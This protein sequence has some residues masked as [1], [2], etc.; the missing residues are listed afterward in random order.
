MLKKFLI[1]IIFS[2][3]IFCEEKF[4]FVQKIEGV[5][6][7]WTLKHNEI[8][9]V[10]E[11]IVTIDKTERNYEKK[12]LEIAKSQILDKKNNF[13]SSKNGNLLK[14][15]DVTFYEVDSYEDSKKFYLWIVSFDNKE[16]M[17]DF[18]EFLFLKNKE[19]FSKKM[20]SEDSK[21][22]TI[23]EKQ[24]SKITID[25]GKNQN[26]NEKEILEI[27]R[28]S[29]PFINSFTKEPN[30][31]KKTKI[32]EVIAEEV[33]NETTFA[34]GD[35]RTTFL[36]KEGDI[37]E[38]TGL[39]YT[40]PETINKD[41]KKTYIVDYIPQV[42]NIEKSEILK[43]KQYLLNLTSDF[44]SNN[45]FIAKIGVLQFVEATFG[46]NLD[47]DTPT[48]G[49]IK[50]AFPIDEK[51][52][53][54]GLAYKKDFSNGNSYIIGLAQGSFYSNM[55]LTSLSISS[56]IE[57]DNSE[58][59]GASI[60]ILPFDKIILGL[61]FEKE[62]DYNNEKLSPKISF[63]VLD[64]TWAGFGVIVDND[65]YKYFIDLNRIS[66]F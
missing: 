45:L 18:K 42:K 59:F 11:G 7:W 41:F 51:P 61:E 64:D 49:I 9:G 22:I 32:G 47:K 52:L 15:D 44:D 63:K 46:A 50:V 21:K 24:K 19:T 4:P 28:F 54:L 34:S 23:I 1:L 38:P 16:S 36:V 48:Y 66:I 12:A 2:F 39:F 58:I 10:I 20:L 56:P 8:N 65:E 26:I 33:F 5:T 35:I 3:N 40:V 37:V 14:S 17:N 25:G 60:Q 30:E 29:D 31:I 55:L 27:Y 62:L 43:P 13:I 53:Y 57:L 6:P